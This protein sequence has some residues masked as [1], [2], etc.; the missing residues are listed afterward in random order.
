M[1]RKLNSKHIIKKRTKNKLAG[2]YIHIP[3]CR[4]AC[5]YCDFHFS[6]STDLEDL[7]IDAIC[8]EI[9]ERKDYLGTKILNTVYFGGGT[10]SILKYYNVEKI[11]NAISKHFDIS[12]IQ[13]VTL[14]ANPDDINKEK[15]HFYKT[16]TPVNRFSL[17]VQSFQ[18]EDLKLMNRAH[19]A[20]ESVNSIKLIQDAGFDKITIDLIYGV[21]TL[22][23]ENWEANLSM[24]ETLN[25][26]HLS[27]YCLTIEKK[28]LLENRISKGELK[29]VNE[30]QQA[31]HFEMLL[32]FAKQNN[33]EQYE[34]SNFAK[35][36]QYAIHNT[37]YWKSKMYLGVGP[38]AH[39]FD[40][41]S[42]IKNVSNNNLYI[43]NIAD[44][45]K[46]QEIEKLT[47]E[48]RLNEYILTSLRTMWGCDLDHVGVSFGATRLETVLKKADKWI[49]SNELI[50]KENKLLLTDKGKL[51]AD[52]ITSYLFF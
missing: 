36:E 11:F 4:Q 42:R 18:E 2:L 9:E 21:Q 35:A 5:S 16:Q 17:G 48:E 6:T 7:M 14:E 27:A 25:I 26:K 13:E 33:F 19:S 22:T 38:S 44:L 12:A 49:K 20:L 45:S 39:S 43:K 1:Q 51:V 31:K 29:N 40:G 52:Y 28:T 10:P 47:N 32:A 15:L 50:V 41:L 23:D 46:I 3:F 24:V 8:K 34:I 30:S 37:N